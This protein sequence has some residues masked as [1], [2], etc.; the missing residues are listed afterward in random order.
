MIHNA[1]M[2]GVLVTLL[3]TASITQRLRDY[4]GKYVTVLECPYCTSFWV[5]LVVDPSSTY[6]TTVL[7][8][9]IAVMLIHWS[10]ATY[11][12]EDV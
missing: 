1:A 8:G 12:D 6:L 9:N 7:T 5:A 2:V 11:A 3:C 4:V 10:M